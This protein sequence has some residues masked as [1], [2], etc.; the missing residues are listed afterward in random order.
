MNRAPCGHQMLGYMTG[1]ST[2]NKC[3][4]LVLVVHMNGLYL[5]QNKIII[6]WF[7]SLQ[8]LYNTIYTSV[9]NSYCKF[10]ESS[11]RISNSSVVRMSFSLRKTESHSNV[12]NVTK[13]QLKYRF[14]SYML[15][16]YNLYF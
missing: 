10:L 2:G 1:Q 12:E 5:H 3:F 13:T 14:Q 9:N 16:L 7:N 8:K 4:S 6:M 11:E 15:T